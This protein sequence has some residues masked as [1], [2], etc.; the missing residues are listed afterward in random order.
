[1]ANITFNISGSFPAEDVLVYAKARG[2]Q[3]V[4]PDGLDDDGN[5]KTKPNPEAPEV[6]VAKY[7]KDYLVKEIAGVSEA[8]IRSEYETQLKARISGLYN[9]VKGNVSV[10]V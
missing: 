1:M 6:Y 9:S 5:I 8:K 10:K 7:I 4:L 2:Y 3:E